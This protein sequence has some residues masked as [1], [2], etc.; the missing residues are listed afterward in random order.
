MS[1]DAV[2]LLFALL[3]LACQIAVLT[4]VVLV[5]AGR[6]NPAAARKRRELVDLVSGDA[7][8]LAALV[9]GV[10]TAG[11]LYLSEGAGFPPCRLCWVQRGFMYPLAVILAVAAWRR[12]RRVALFAAVAA[13]AGGSVSIYHMVLERYPSLESSASCDPDN[14]CSL[15]WVEHFGY[16]TIPTMALSGFAM[17]VVLTLAARAGS[18]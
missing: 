3:A 17:I 7:L 1:V 6:F 10:A 8:A 13:A 15:I 11:S 9:A 4:A 18:D 14:P 16:M 2:T 5:V 12:A